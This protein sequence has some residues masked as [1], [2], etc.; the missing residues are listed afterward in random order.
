MHVVLSATKVASEQTGDFVPIQAPA[1]SRPRSVW[2][3]NSGYSSQTPMISGP[4]EAAMQSTA[5]GWSAPAA[6]LA[7]HGSLKLQIVL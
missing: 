1:Q 3:S 7:L 5:P 2:M 4:A 6:P